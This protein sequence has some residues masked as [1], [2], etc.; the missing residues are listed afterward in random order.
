MAYASCNIIC[1]SIFLL[2]KNSLRI[3]KI[4]LE[5]YLLA[6]LYSYLESSLSL[7]F[8]SNFVSLVCGI[9]RVISFSRPPTRKSFTSFSV[10]GDIEN[11]RM[12]SI[13]GWTCSTNSMMDA[14]CW[15][16]TLLPMMSIGN[17]ESLEKT[18]LFQHEIIMN[19]VLLAFSHLMKMMV[20]NFQNTRQSIASLTISAV[21][22]S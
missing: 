13:S 16:L 18:N 2:Y 15:N 3:N 5:S 1:S 21:F 8:S 4:R 17:S 6:E 20:V 7:S 19:Y 14:T 22:S 11:A 9:N 10:N 12:L